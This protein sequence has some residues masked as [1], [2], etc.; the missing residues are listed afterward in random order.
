MAEELLG[1]EPIQAPQTPRVARSPDEAIVGEGFTLVEAG[2]L[3]SLVGMPGPVQLAPMPR[4]QPEYPPRQQLVRPDTWM[5]EYMMGQEVPVPFAAGGVAGG[6][7][8]PLTVQEQDGTPSVTNVD[9]IKVPNG[10]LTDLGGGDVSLNYESPINKNVANGYAGLD[11]GGRIAKAQAPSTTVYTDDIQT[12][13][14]SGAKKTIAHTA[15][16]AN[17]AGL[18]VA[19]AAGAPGSITA[20]D[21]WNDAGRLQFADTGGVARPIALQE[22]ALTTGSVLFANGSAR[23]D[24]DNAS[25]FWD[26]VNK[27]LGI[28]TNVPIAF[29]DIRNNSKDILFNILNGTVGNEGHFKVVVN[30][31][32]A[33]DPYN[34]GMDVNDFEKFTMSCEDGGNRQA[35]VFGDGTVA[36]AATIF[37]IATSINSGVTWIPRLVVKQDGSIGI[38][39]KDQ[40]GSGAGV[41]GLANAIT[42]PTTNPT[43][44]H[45]LYA[46]AGAFK[47]RGSSGTITTIAA[48]EPHCPRC[49]RDFA[50]EWENEKYGK[51]SICAWCLSDALE[52]LG[53]DIVIE[54]VAA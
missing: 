52:K 12:I 49:G 38:G 7:G 19:S 34:L 48:A 25:F 14:A 42:V 54:K 10:T 23:I 32:D 9:L 47:G 6:G 13:G 28:K 26:N 1:G 39:T 29:V 11:A 43:G 3:G 15:G 5:Q 21:I 40:F 24:Q 16:G 41:I 35:L 2:L 31:N 44:G 17:T 20:G 18:N 30:G 36:N 33:T 4:F 53:I 8:S 22:G 27:R 37:G 51:L 46:E 50:H 45:V